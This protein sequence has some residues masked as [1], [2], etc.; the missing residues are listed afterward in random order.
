[1]SAEDREMYERPYRITSSIFEITLR[2]KS[3]KTGVKNVWLAARD[4]NP[5]LAHHRGVR[6]GGRKLLSRARR[7]TRSSRNLGSPRAAPRWRP[8]GRGTCRM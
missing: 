7:E 1:M 8:S 6:A 3:L 5:Q 2:R 4:G